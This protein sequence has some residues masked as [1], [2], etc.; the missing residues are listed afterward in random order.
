MKSIKLENALD[1]V[2][3]SSEF[4][5]VVNEAIKYFFKLE[6]SRQKLFLDAAFEIYNITKD[7]FNSITCDSVKDALERIYDPN[8]K[9]VLEFLLKEKDTSG[10][11]IFKKKIVIIPTKCPN[12][13]DYKLGVPIQHHEDRYFLRPGYKKK[14]GNNMSNNPEDFRAPAFAEV[15]FVLVERN[16]ADPTL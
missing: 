10:K 2:V 1:E 9:C 5:P 4:D 15:L 12:S 14:I 8:V 6:T 11:V 7:W 13:H 16:R 3:K